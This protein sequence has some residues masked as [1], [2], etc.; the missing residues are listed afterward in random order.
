MRLSEDVPTIAGINHGFSFPLRYFDYYR[1]DPEWVSFLDDFQK[2]WPTDDA[3]TYVDF[4]RVGLRGD[5]DARSGHVRWRRKTEE[6]AGAKSVFQFEGGGRSAKSTHAG[7]PWLRYLRHQLGGKV[8]FWPFDG[9]EISVGKSVVVE[10]YPPLWRNLYPREGRTLDQ[11]NAFVTTA[12][13]RQVDLDGSL[14]KFLKPDLSP[15]DYVV[16]Q[17]EGWILGVL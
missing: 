10:V 7:L 3:Y 13:L 5:G 4:V 11:Q 1:L 16:A 6:R 2:H 17:L 9:W 15:D 8:Y 14:E 12:W